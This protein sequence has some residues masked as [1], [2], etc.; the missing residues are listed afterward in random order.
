[1]ALNEAVR[2]QIETA[3]NSDEV[4][5]FMKGTPQQPQCGFSATVIGILDKL[6][7][8]YTTVNVL[9]DAGIRDGIKDFSAW[10]TI[11][12]LYVG[13]EFL[14]GCDIVKQMFNSGD[15]HQA[16]GVP[17]PDRTPPALIISDA[18]AESSAR[19][20][21][22]V[23]ITAGH[24]SHAARCS[25]GVRWTPGKDKPRGANKCDLT[26]SSFGSQC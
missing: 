24:F 20:G 25:F 1:M 26:H 6:V 12:Q 17:A 13:Q 23:G 3:I 11:P 2:T 18:A 22:G 4:V 9:Q 19:S 21:R 8:S 7:P 14:G 5:L 15:L 16:L 10:P